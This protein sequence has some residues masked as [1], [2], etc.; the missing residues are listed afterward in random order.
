MVMWNHIPPSSK[1]LQAAPTTSTTWC[2]RYFNTQSS[3]LPVWRLSAKLLP[4]SFFAEPTEFASLCTTGAWRPGVLQPVCD[5]A[6]GAT[7]HPCGELNIPQRRWGG[8]APCPGCHEEH[9]AVAGGAD[10]QL[11]GEGCRIIHSRCILSLRISE[12]ILLCCDLKMVKD[13]R[14][15]IEYSR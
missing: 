9:Q 15:T 8:E 3:K 2:V 13:Y 7:R 4:K 1:T 11:Q 12:M 14:R 5:P 10:G 6:V